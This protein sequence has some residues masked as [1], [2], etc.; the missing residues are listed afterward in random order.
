MI[1]ARSAFCVNGGDKAGAIAQKRRISMIGGA[2]VR[3][4]DYTLMWIGSGWPTIQEQLGT[5]TLIARELR[6][7]YTALAYMSAL[8]AWRT[9]RISVLVS[10]SVSPSPLLCNGVVVS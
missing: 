7:E 9:G 2:K 4:A 8:A 1:R 6:R 5:P 3:N 10:V